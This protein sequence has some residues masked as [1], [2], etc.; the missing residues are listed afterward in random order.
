MSSLSTRLKASVSHLQ[1]KIEEGID[2]GKFVDAIPDTSLQHYFS[3]VIEEFGCGQYARELT[4]PKG[5]TFVGK[6][7][8]HPHISI[9]LK[10]EL[11]VVSESGRI[12][13][14]APHTWVSPIGAKRAFYAV[15]DS[16]MTTVHITKQ[17]PNLDHLDAIEDEL[18]TDSYSSIGLPEPNIE[19]YFQLG[20]K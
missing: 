9:L 17:E 7:H 16:V 2:E 20:K 5:M 15:E 19:K 1:N 18:I 13:M 4:V 6:I 12:H 3:P 10:G 14:K 11:V 8:K